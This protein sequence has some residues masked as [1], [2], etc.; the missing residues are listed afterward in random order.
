M[1]RRWSSLLVCLLVLAVPT[2]WLFVAQQRQP[3]DPTNRALK[4]PT[5]ADAGNLRELAKLLP[6]ENVVLLAF[7]VPGGLPILPVD[8]AAI[9]DCRER[10]AALPGVIECTAPPAPDDSLALLAAALAGADLAATQRRVIDCAERIRPPSLRLLATGM[11]L[12]EAR[13]AELIALERSTIVPIIGVCLFAASWL[14]YRR[15]GLAAAALVPAV[16]AIVWTS[17]IVA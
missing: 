8:R 15:V 7:Q 9:A 13:V 2:V 17:G 3:V 14:L 1:S 4:D 11:P 5:S 6:S 16:L 10:I 12:Y